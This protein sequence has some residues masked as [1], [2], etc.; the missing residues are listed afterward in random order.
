MRVKKSLRTP[1]R[2][3]T[4][5]VSGLKERRLSAQ[6]RRK[7]GRGGGG[8]RRCNKLGRTPP[9]RAA[10]PQDSSVIRSY[11]SDLEKERQVDAVSYGERYVEKKTFR[12]YIWVIS[13]WRSCQNCVNAPKLLV[14]EHQRDFLLSEFTTDQ[15]MICFCV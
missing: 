9:L 13:I 1:I 3:L 8:H 12:Y 14:H 4:S 10:H 6:R 11:H 5:C 2:K 15:L 7:R